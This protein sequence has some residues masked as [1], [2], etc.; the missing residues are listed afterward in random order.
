MAYEAGRRHALTAF[1]IEK[2]AG[3][4]GKVV[5]GIGKAMKWVG[6]AA[7]TV[8][9]F[10]TAANAA[11][12][13]AGGLAEGLAN[14]GMTRKGLTEGLARAGTNIATGSIPGG[15]GIAAGLAGDVA[16][17]KMFAQ[18]APAGPQ[19]QHLPGMMGSG[20]HLPGQTI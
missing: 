6:R 13:G 1:A 19:P 8:P 18:K 15:A 4:L 5:G 3:V 14:Q 2:N 7:G 11:I 17:D 10:G 12:G 16:M 9:A 20:A